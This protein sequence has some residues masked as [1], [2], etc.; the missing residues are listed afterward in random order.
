[1][2]ACMPDNMQHARACMS[3]Y[4]YDALYRPTYTRDDLHY[5][6]A[7]IMRHDLYIFWTVLILHAAYRNN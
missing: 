6:Y 7:H 3:M 4:S 5:N 2:H 1:M